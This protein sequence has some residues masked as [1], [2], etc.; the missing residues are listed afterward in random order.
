[1][2]VVLTVSVAEE[3]IEGDEYSFC[4]LI[5]GTRRGSSGFSQR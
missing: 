2:S 4:D 1:M 5:V 3:D